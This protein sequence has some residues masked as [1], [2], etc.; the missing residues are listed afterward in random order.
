MRP[1]L[2]VAEIHELT[3]W[4]ERSIR[5]WCRNGVIPGAYQAAYGG[6]WYVPRRFLEDLGLLA[7]IADTKSNRD[8]LEC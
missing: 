8:T 1:L 5:H 2:T 3:G 6:S 4:S 7:D